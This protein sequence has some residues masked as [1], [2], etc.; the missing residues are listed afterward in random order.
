M[1][2]RNLLG[3]AFGL[4]L[5][6]FF[7]IPA[8]AQTPASA[9]GEQVYRARCA[10]C[11]DTAGA[12][13][14]D[15]AALGRMSADNLRFALMSG[16]MRSVGSELPVAEL[17]AVVRYLAS[18]G[19]TSLPLRRQAPTAVQSVRLR[20][21]P[22]TRLTGTAGAFALSQ[23]GFQPASMSRLAAADIPS[24]KAKWAFGFP[25][26]R[27]AYAQPTVVGGR[28]FVGSAGQKGLFAGHEDRLRIL[29]LGRHGIPGASRHHDRRRRRPL[30]G[31]LRRPRA[32]VYTVDASSG[33]LVWKRRIEEHAAAVIT[34]A[35]TLSGGTL[36]VPTSSGEEGV[37]ANPR[38]QCCTFSWERD[39]ADGVE[40]RGPL[41][42]LRDSGGAAAKSV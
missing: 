29:E 22:W 42:E 16:S 31:V 27:Q 20:P 24:L 2:G 9:G 37:G 33:A 13:V 26:V 39:G 17:D 12:R 21:R 6:V 3:V 11:H 41:E 4:G 34:G 14:P 35:P 40:R 32:T 10:S 38:Y 28:L 7:T 15:R 19:G 5:G 1:T 18:G 8:A 25:G 36:Y 23:L 30:A